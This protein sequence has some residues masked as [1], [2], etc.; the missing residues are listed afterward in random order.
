MALLA[1]LTPGEEGS[2]G[3]VLE[4]L[5]DALARP[6]RA[7]KVVPCAN[8]LRHRHTLMEGMSGSDAHDYH[9]GTKSGWMWDGIARKSIQVRGPY[10][11]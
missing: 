4:H 3:R 8:P 7:L 10:I 9:G 6:G 5:T 2:T 11:G 1:A